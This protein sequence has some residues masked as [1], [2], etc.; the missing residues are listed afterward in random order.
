MVDIEEQ[1]DYE[2]RIGSFN[3]PMDLLLYLVQKKEMSLDQI[4]IAEIADDPKNGTPPLSK[5]TTKIAK[6]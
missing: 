1:E 6:S 4:P 5:N 2:V 3:G